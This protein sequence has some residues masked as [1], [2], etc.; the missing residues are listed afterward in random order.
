MKTQWKVGLIFDTAGR[1][2]Q[3]TDRTAT[4]EP[5]GPAA[6]DDIFAFFR[7]PGGVNGL[8]ESRR[9]LFRGKQV[10]MGITVAGSE[11]ALAM[12]YDDGSASSGSR[13]RRFRRKTRRILKKFRYRRS[14]R[15]PERSCSITQSAVT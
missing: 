14:G 11:G 8:F 13:I 6:G 2:L 1:P 7:F 9:N 3:R 15:F 10:R 5:I 12:R 4:S